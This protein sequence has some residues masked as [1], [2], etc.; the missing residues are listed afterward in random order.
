MGI[1]L[2]L[3][4]IAIGAV[5]AF[6][7]NVT[8]SGLDLAVVGWILMLIGVLGLV[9][10]LV[11]WPRRRATRVERVERAVPPRQQVVERQVYE[12]PPL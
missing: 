10:S 8:V 7:T 6:A 3:M 2:S 11:V 5:L 12:D 1:A 4:A 9:L